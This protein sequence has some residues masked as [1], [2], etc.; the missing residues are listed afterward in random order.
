MKESLKNQTITFLWMAM[1]T[2]KRLFFELLKDEQETEEF[3]I[4]A[5]GDTRSLCDALEF[6]NAWNQRHGDKLM[7][8][9]D[10]CI[11][12]DSVAILEL[13][14]ETCEKNFKYVS[15]FGCSSPVSFNTSEGIKTMYPGKR[16]DDNLNE[17]NEIE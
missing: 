2:F 11:Y 17:L 12:S 10:G 3:G 8:H 14:R 13:W 4:W 7:L 16:Y 15:E 5:F 6:M 1:T 9:S